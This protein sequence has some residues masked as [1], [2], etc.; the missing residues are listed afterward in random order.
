MSLCAFKT[1]TESRFHRKTIASHA[2][3][4]GKKRP[5]P[6]SFLH[7]DAPSKAHNL[8]GES[9]NQ[10]TKALLCTEKFT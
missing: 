6:I 4:C 7:V 3:S 8:V 1:I 9:F 2:N 5:D 10:T